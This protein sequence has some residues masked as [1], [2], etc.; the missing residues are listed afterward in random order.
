M[1][2]MKVSRATEEIK[3][4]LL[5][6]RHNFSV[7]FGLSVDLLGLVPLRVTGKSLA[8]RALGNAAEYAR[9]FHIGW[10]WL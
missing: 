7:G 2:G 5:K 9:N 10:V 8:L 1:F 6:F 3:R 4:V